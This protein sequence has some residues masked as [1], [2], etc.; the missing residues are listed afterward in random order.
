M[1]L[2]YPVEQA[3]LADYFGVRRPDALRGLDIWAPGPRNAIHLEDGNDEWALP[4][5]VARIALSRIQDRLPQWY[6]SRG[7]EETFA[8]K[9]YA[10]T[11]GD[12]LLM[13]LH[14][15]TINWADSGPGMSWP[16]AYHLTW[17]PEFD[18]YVVTASADCPDVWGYEDRALGHFGQC[19]DRLKRARKI[20]TTF[21]RDQCNG[22]DAGRWAYLFDTGAVDSEE[23]YAWAEDVWPLA[24][25]D[26]DEE[27]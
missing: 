11:G 5:A 14:L 22:G 27:A 20:V 10:T 17:F 4:N 24:D 15:F 1:K 9:E 13:P 21:W 8:R 12:V 23:A 6:A 26:D 25:E 16:E 3:L 2:Y 18:R 19:G 7:G